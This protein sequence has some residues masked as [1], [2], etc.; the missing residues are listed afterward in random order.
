MGDPESDVSDVV[1]QAAADASAL[2]PATDLASPGEFDALPADAADPEEIQ[3]AIDAAAGYIDVTVEEESN[4]DGMESLL[5]LLSAI[6][7]P[8]YQAATTASPIVLDGKSDDGSGPERRSSGLQWLSTAAKL[9][10]TP[11]E[12]ATA[13]HDPARCLSSPRIV[14]PPR[15]SYLETTP[16]SFST[17]LD[18]DCAMD[19]A[20]PV[21]IDDDVFG[22]PADVVSPEPEKRA[23]GGA[24]ADGSTPGFTQPE[25]EAAEP[26]PDST[27]ARR[28][29]RQAG[30]T[31]LSGYE[32]SI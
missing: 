18:L 29:S 3:P 5:P 12:G 26:F 28:A 17:S 11:D 1:M 25:A 13:K 31:G 4:E 20:N 16:G 21:F 8:S 15:Y 22:F 6:K 24:I 30:V 32:S 2:A 14:R 27:G 19:L 9:E 23:S 10:G 7:R